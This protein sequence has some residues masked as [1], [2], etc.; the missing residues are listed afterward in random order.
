MIKQALIGGL[1]PAF[2]L[3]S[4]NAGVLNDS[5]PHPQEFTY[6]FV[7]DASTNQTTRTRELEDALEEISNYGNIKLY[8]TTN[9]DFQTTVITPL[10]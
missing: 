1:I 6:C 10:N 2:F 7:G 8:G 3:N 5:S 4:A 9:A